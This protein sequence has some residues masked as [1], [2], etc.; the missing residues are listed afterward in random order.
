MDPHS[1]EDS[2]RKQR[3]IKLLSANL[4]QALDAFT[5]DGGRHQHRIRN[6]DPHCWYGSISSRPK[7]AIEVAQWSVSLHGLLNSAGV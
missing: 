2:E 7:E 5:S 6:M 1:L 4:R 3:G